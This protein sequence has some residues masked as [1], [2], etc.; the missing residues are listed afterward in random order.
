M[1]ASQRATFPVLLLCNFVVDPGPP[2]RPYDFMEKA[3]HY[4][5]H[6]RQT[7][8]NHTYGK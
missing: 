7:T 8:H 1:E 2:S 5:I 3:T 4:N 6:L